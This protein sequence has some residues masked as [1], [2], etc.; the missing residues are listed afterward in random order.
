MP[1][2]NDDQGEGGLGLGSQLP[3]PHNAMMKELAQQIALLKQKKELRDLEVEYD[4]FERDLAERRE[5]NTPEHRAKETAATRLNLELERRS[6]GRAQDKAA[7]E[8]R[9]AGAAKR[10]QEARDDRKALA[11]SLKKQLDK[12]RVGDLVLPSAPSSFSPDDV[13][14]FTT[15]AGIYEFVPSEIVAGEDGDFF[16][17]TEEQ[18]QDLYERIGADRGVVFDPTQEHVFRP[19][20]R[21]VLRGPV[22]E[23]VLEDDLRARAGSLVEKLGRLE[24]QQ[25]MLEQE[26]GRWAPSAGTKSSASALDALLQDALAR[27]ERIREA[28]GLAG[29][30]GQSRAEQIIEE[31]IRSLD[32]EDQAI[33][34]ADSGAVLPAGL[35]T[36]LLESERL[37]GELAAKLDLLES[38][39][40]GD[41]CRDQIWGE[42]TLPPAFFMQRA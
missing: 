13:R 16:A 26:I 11:K 35:V 7:L 6:Q 39:A 27:K 1:D 29:D 38:R 24:A 17:L 32:A 42:I 37:R 40:R 15:D 34:V 36:A 18:A 33:D 25:T 20:F 31:R 41:C 22:T 9:R 21:P 28:L 8:E 3:S 10:E 30:A 4:A 2:D 5:R 14:D 23:S 12:T 19:G